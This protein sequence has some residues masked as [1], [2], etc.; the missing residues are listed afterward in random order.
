M[1]HTPEVVEGPEAFKRFDTTVRAILAAP[2]A[3][4]VR[5]EQEY[6]KQAALRPK[7]RPKK[8]QNDPIHAKLKGSS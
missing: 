7:R 4:L 5:R 2:R 3:E 6:Q 1:P 8:A